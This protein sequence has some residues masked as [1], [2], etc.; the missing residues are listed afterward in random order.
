MSKRCYGCMKLKENSPVCEH[1]GYN[2]NVPN[3]SHQLPV[4]TILHG[5]YT[6]GKV[7]GQGGFGIT[8]IGWDSQLEVPVA[9]KEY[10]PSS[11]VN[12][13]CGMTLNVTCNGEGAEELY[14]RNRERF[15][16]EAKILAKLQNVPGIVRVQNL[17][18]ENNTAYIVM[19]YVEGI[20]LK[21]YIRMQQRVLTVQ[22]TF[23][24]LRPVMYALSKVH[25]AELVHRDISPD[26]I[27]ILPDGTAKLLDFGAAREVENADVYAELPQ[28]TEAILKHGFAPM[29]QYRR[30]GSLG[31]WTDV[32]ALCAT[33]YYCLTGKVPN[34]APERIMGDDN[35]NWHQ[36]PGLTQQQ[37]TTLEKG[38]AL[39]PENRLGSMEQLYQGLF[40]QQKQNAQPRPAPKASDVMET[41]RRGGSSTLPKAAKPERKKK[42]PTALIAAAL[43]AVAAAGLF[44]LKPG[45]KDITVEL[46]EILPTV[47][48]ATETAPLSPEQLA[49]LEAEELAAQGKH[50][51]AGIAFAK[52]GDYEDARERSFEE[53]SYTRKLNTISQTWAY[54]Y[55]RHIL[56]IKNDGTVVS[57]GTNTWGQLAVGAWSD[58]I[59][60]C[61]VGRA[62]AGLKADGTVVVVGDGY[63]GAK[64]WTN[65]V[66]LYSA[67]NQL[68]GLAEDGSVMFDGPG[69]NDEAQY[70]KKNF[71]SISTFNGTIA[72]LCADGTVYLGNTNTG[73][74]LM[75]TDAEWKDIISIHAY[76]EEIWAIRAD[77]SVLIYDPDADTPFVHLTQFHDAVDICGPVILKADGTVE[78]YPEDAVYYIPEGKNKKS[79][80]TS[81][82]KDLEGWSD[83]IAIY[84]RSGSYYSN[85][86]ETVYGL[87]AD[88]TVVVAGS[89]YNGSKNVDSWTDIVAI[90]PGFW[91]TIGM[92]SD[93]SV[94]F[95]ETVDSEVENWTD[96]RL[97]TPRMLP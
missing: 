23:S 2:E 92:K 25:E 47:T 9:I 24:V 60:V 65:I 83:V 29:E 93:G 18:A 53:W 49:Y 70:D 43:A 44:F 81:W 77:G 74:F 5:Q 66:A 48:E 12:R 91:L 96:I 73:T 14:Q 95:A 22:E 45:E 86:D 90:V 7:L 71:I 87:R 33:I 75:V 17:F 20:D 89:G 61:A 40:P 11:F 79:G 62:S 64:K 6:V 59:E 15:L 76:Y 94:I 4:G 42:K 97:P 88:G 67:N 30:R 68:I 57:A 35:V 46:P 28:S 16:K 51:H 50:A 36:I 19:E 8:Y 34:S 84:G 13:D 26:N 38:L 27:M 39:M 82:I 52:L 63:K 32:Y 37:I 56:G 85:F 1:C 55:D 21:H 80:Q 69:Y 78:V 58:L 54:P 10:Y 31:P 72:A 41:T 3:Y